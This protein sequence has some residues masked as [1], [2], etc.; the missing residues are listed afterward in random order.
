MAAQLHQHRQGY[1]HS[2]WIRGRTLSNTVRFPPFEGYLLPDGSDLPA[3]IAGC[4]GPPEGLDPWQHHRAR[5]N[6]IW[7][8]VQHLQP[9]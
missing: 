2:K 3:T 1:R 9:C 6:R 8:D 5:S 7:R 4:H